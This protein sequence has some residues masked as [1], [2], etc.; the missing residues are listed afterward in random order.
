MSV[1][2]WLL[3]VSKEADV[4]GTLETMNLKERVEEGWRRM[5]I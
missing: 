1:C 5:R 3:T 2:A 4:C